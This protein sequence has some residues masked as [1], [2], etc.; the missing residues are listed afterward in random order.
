V[1][2]LA[3]F[4][5]FDDFSPLTTETTR[6]KFKRGEDGEDK[7]DEFEEEKKKQTDEDIIVYYLTCAERGERPKREFFMCE[8]KSSYEKT[9]ADAKGKEKERTGREERVL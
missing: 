8:R 9:V 1:R 2:N 5:R 4:L 7:T 6:K 3:T